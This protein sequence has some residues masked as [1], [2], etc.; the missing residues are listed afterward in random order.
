MLSHVKHGYTNRTDHH[1]TTVRKT[2]AGPD[3]ELRQ[4]A[5]QHALVALRGRIPVPPVAATGPGWLETEFVDAVHGQDLIDGGRAR[6]VLE[7]CG[8]LLRRLHALDPRL[9]D[10][11]ASEDQVLVHGDFGPNNLLFDRDADAVLSV[12]DWEFSG[13][14]DAVTDIAWCEWIV[15]MHHP[16]AVNE[17]PAFFDT[18]GATPSWSLRR[19]AMLR[20]CRRLADFTSRWDPDGAGVALWQQR[21][22]AVESWTE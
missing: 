9:I 11:T 2:Y 21:A 13:V 10:P 22:R 6:P 19:D 8:L 14:G 3:A 4:A 18:Y 16:D 1:G 12:L 5:E 20:R 15:R 7:G 17:L